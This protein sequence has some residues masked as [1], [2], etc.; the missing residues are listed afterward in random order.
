MLYRRL[1]E[2]SVCL[3]FNLMTLRRVVINIYLIRLYLLIPVIIPVLY[4]L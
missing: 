1:R 3:F 2:I 4:C